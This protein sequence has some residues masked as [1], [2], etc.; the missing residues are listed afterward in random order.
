MELSRKNQKFDE[1]F[2]HHSLFLSL[3]SIIKP[4]FEELF[5]ER[6]SPDQAIRTRKIIRH[7]NSARD[8]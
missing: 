1:S 4:D 6:E 3:F 8:E 5:D 2:R 7:A